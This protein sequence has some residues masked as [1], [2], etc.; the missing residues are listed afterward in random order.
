MPRKVKVNTIHLNKGQTVEEK[1]VETWGL[2][3]TTERESIAIAI[4]VLNAKQQELQIL[5]AGYYGIWNGL[6]AK[7]DLPEEF[8]Y[9][10]KTGRL[11]PKGEL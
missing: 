3:T 11:G 10:P 9:D 7:Y 5:R 4:T 2:L 8:S 6:L 1:H